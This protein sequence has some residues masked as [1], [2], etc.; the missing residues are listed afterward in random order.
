MGGRVWLVVASERIKGK[1]E[2]WHW[3]EFFRHRHEWAP[4]DFSWGGYE[5][6]RSPVSLR[7]VRAMRRGDIVVA[8]QAGEGIVGL[9]ALASGGYEEVPGTGDLNTFDLAPEPALRLDHPVPLRHL[10]TDAATAPLFR[11][12]QGSVFEATEFWDG[13][14]RHILA[15]NPHLAEALRIFER[16]V[17]RLRKTTGAEKDVWAKMAAERAPTYRWRGRTYRRKGEQSAWLRRLY[18]FRC[19]IC[20]AQF[21]TPDGRMVIEVH[22]LRPLTVFGPRADHPGNMLVLC[23]NHHLQLELSEEVRVDWD[24]KRIRFNGTWRR[25]RCHPLHVQ[26][27][28]AWRGEL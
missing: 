8:Y 27:A 23:P 28:K 22:Y 4:A 17:Q 20:G 7:C 13:I 6:I 16:Q 5:W 1:P 11:Q 26:S 18:D 12:L 10:K 24:G 25:L 14:K 15:N 21:L 19:Q 2:G 3:D 9:A